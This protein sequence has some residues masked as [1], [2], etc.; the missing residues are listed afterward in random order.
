M[1]PTVIVYWN[2]TG[3]KI[4]ATRRQHEPSQAEFQGSMVPLCE[5]VR[6][7]LFD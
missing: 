6:K 2:Q 5:S 4:Y 3:S 1:T 7:A